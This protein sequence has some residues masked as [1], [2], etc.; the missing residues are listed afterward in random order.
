MTTPVNPTRRLGAYIEVVAD[1]VEHGL[2]AVEFQQR[3]SDMY[4]NDA[5]MWSDEEFLVLDS[6]FA[7]T[8][9]FEPDP[10]VRAELDHTIDANELYARAVRALAELR[11]LARDG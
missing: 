9:F 2:P 3:F 4:L 7:E 1:F 8:D 10:E 5:T 11:E 6:L